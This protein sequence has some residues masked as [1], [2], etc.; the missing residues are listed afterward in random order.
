MNI[1]HIQPGDV[2][3]CDIRGI[4]FFATVTEREKGQLVIQ[5]HSRQINHYRVKA[6]QVAGHYKKMSG[7]R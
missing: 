2:V 5:P 7:S 1:T 6:T 3:E 4:K